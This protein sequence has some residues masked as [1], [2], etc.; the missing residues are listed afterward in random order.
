MR[1]AAAIPL[2]ILGL[3]VAGIG[4]ASVIERNWFRLR[5]FD[6][7]VLAPGQRPV[8]ILQISDL[9][10]TPRRHRLIEW[11]RSLASLDPDLVVNTG[12]TLAHPDAVES[13]MYAV[14]PLLDRPGL[15]VYGSNDMYAP[16]PKN[17]VRYLWRTS[18]GDPRQH[19]PNLPWDELGAAMR[20]AGWL[21][22]NNATARLKVA[23]LDVHVG[24]IH[25]SH[26]DRDRYDEIA[27]QAPVDADLR[28]GVM[29]SPEPRNMSRFAQDGYQV[30]LAGHT[31]GGQLC[32]P[33]YGALVTNCG[34]DRARVKGL[35]RHESAWLHVSAGLGTSPYA[36]A[37]FACPPEATLLTLVPRRPVVPDDTSSRKVR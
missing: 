8:R 22:M 17:P 15:F 37:R 36:P 4:Y 10:L 23:D 1:K 25:D 2:S 29:H 35:S 12:D 6:V 21:D 9:H 26:I 27:G 33:F 11:V 18:K 5:R 14:E 16:R 13:Y 20:E 32:I 30:L 3:G 24:G 19:V 31:H 28:L 7:P 34:I